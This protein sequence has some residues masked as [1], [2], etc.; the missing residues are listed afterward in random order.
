MWTSAKEKLL[1]EGFAFKMEIHGLTDRAVGA[2]RG[3]HVGGVDLL[4][5]AVSMSKDRTDAARLLSRPCLREG[6]HLA[7]ALYSYAHLGKPFCE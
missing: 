2:L 5:R 6:N 1:C 3:D 4:E 7:G